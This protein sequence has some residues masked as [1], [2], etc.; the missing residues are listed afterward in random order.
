[1]A[2]NDFIGFASNGNANIAS[3][4]DYA[5][6]AEQTSGVQ[7]GPASSK[8]ANKAWRQGCNMAAAIGT[9]TAARGFDA[10]DNGDVEALANNV[11]DALNV[12]AYTQLL[13]SQTSGSFIA[14]STGVY[15]ITI[16][17]G[18]GGGG[19]AFTSPSTGSG[20]GGG[21]GGQTLLYASLIAGTSYSYTIGAGGTGGAAGGG[22]NFGADGGTSSITVDGTTYQAPGGTGGRAYSG[23]GSSGAGGEPSNSDAFDLRGVPGAAGAWGSSNQN[24]GSGGGFGGGKG[25]LYSGTSGVK[26]GGGSGGG[27]NAGS[28]SNGS[29]GGDGFILIEYA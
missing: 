6:A 16:K 20:G 10:L 22:G 14:P 26:G 23:G 11:R 1:M 13:F 4:V 9:I 28:A 21:E 8:L 15:R 29:A 19:S 5:A 27:L 3:Q 25:N 7:P 2:T 12:G 17:G 24:G 18:G